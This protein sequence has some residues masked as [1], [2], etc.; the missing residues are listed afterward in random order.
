MRIAV[1]CADPVLAE[2]L[3]C[4]LSRSGGHEIVHCAGHLGD[5]NLLST[6]LPDL[7]IVTEEFDDLPHR[8]ILKAVRQN[9]HRILLLV[10]GRHESSSREIEAD[11]VIGRRQ[12]IGVLFQAIQEFNVPA[13]TEEKERSRQDKGPVSAQLTA[14]ELEVAEL[15]ARGLRNKEIAAIMS[16][17]EANVKALIQRACRTLKCKNRVELALMFHEPPKPKS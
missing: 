10:D 13:T 6:L 2:G 16:T 14:R 4:L 9:G 12:G 5:V 7:I 11:G 17:G 1:F 15:V 8:Q 3:A